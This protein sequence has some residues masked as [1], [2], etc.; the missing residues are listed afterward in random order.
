MI[1]RLHSIQSYTNSNM[2][3]VYFYDG[4][5]LMGLE[6]VTQTRATAGLGNILR[7]E[8]MADVST[9]TSTAY[10]STAFTINPT[11]S[12]I[13]VRLRNNGTTLY[14]DIALDGVSYYP[15]Y[16][17]TVGSFITPTDVGFGGLC[18]TG[19]GFGAQVTLSSWVFLS[20]AAA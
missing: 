1:A 11:T 9:D 6:F 16:S 13:F 10:Q 3:G 15:V 8:R 18:S 20:T 14:F 7:V 4:T 2:T 19:N 12:C 5:K 17:E